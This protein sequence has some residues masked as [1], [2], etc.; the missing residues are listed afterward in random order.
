M[1]R[2]VKLRRVDSLPAAT[3]FKPAGVPMAQLETVVLAMEEVEAI[4]L[5]DIESLHQEQCAQR[6]GISRATFHH[7]LKSAR[8]KV[9][10]AIL[11]G[12]AMR[13]EGG[14]F[15]LPG[16]RFRCRRDGIEWSLPPGA[17]PG[18]SSVACPTCSSKEVQA[19]PV[20]SIR[21]R[22]GRGHGG[23][24]HGWLSSWGAS[25]PPEHQGSRT[26]ADLVRDECELQPTDKGNSQ[27]RRGR[28]T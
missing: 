26:A 22:G 3:F 1:P 10:D 5:K 21:S 2:P 8:S 25:F 7:V 15:A 16:G 18:A 12:K 9:A 6:M 13:V 11:N 24:R 28:S 20:I 19:M 14:V 23:R 17:L 27:A 4:R